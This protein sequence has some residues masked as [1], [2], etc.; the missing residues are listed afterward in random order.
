MG[1]KTLSNIQGD[2]QSEYSQK[3][4]FSTDG[5]N[6]F[7]NPFVRDFAYLQDTLGGQSSFP[8]R[9]MLFPA[10]PLALNNVRMISKT[11]GPPNIYNSN[12]SPRSSPS[13][14][15]PVPGSSHVCRVCSKTFRASSLLDIHM[16]VHVGAKP[17]VCPMC[18][19]RAT[20][21]GN[22]KLHMKKHH[23]AD[24]PPHIDLVPDSGIWGHPQEIALSAGSE[25]G[26]LVDASG[27]KKQ[28]A[29]AVSSLLNEE[30]VEL[31][32]K[33]QN[34]V[35]QGMTGRI[36]E[37]LEDFIRIAKSKADGSIEQ[38][39][40]APDSSSPKSNESIPPGRPKKKRPLNSLRFKPYSAENSHPMLSLTETPW[41]ELGHDV[42]NDT[43]CLMC[44]CSF[45]LNKSQFFSSDNPM[46]P[47]CESCTQL[48][49]YTNMISRQLLLNKKP[50]KDAGQNRISFVEEEAPIT[51]NGVVSEKS[52]KPD[53]QKTFK[54]KF[55]GAVFISKTEFKIHKQTLH[56]PKSEPSCDSVKDEFLK[57]LGLVSKPI[58]DSNLE[59]KSSARHVHGLN[60]ILSSA[61]WQNSKI[62]IAS[63]VITKPK[64][65][66]K[67]TN[68]KKGVSL[69]RA[70]SESKLQISS[71]NRASPGVLNMLRR[72]VLN[73][74][75][76]KLVSSNSNLTNLKASNEVDENMEPDEVFKQDSTP[77]LNQISTSP[78]RNPAMQS[79][80]EIGKTLPRDLSE[81]EPELID[82]FSDAT[83]S[84]IFDTNKSKCTGS[85]SSIFVDIHEQDNGGYKCQFCPKWFKYKSVLEIHMRSH[86]GERP[87][88]C[89]YCEY[90]GT[91]HN[92]LKLHIQRHHPQE[93][94]LHHHADMSSDARG[95]SVSSFSPQSP[96]IAPNRM[97]CFSPVECPICGRVSPSPGYLKIHMRSH[98]K[99]LDHV[100]P[101]CGRGFKEYWYL[102]THLK[103]HERELSTMKYNLQQ[104][105]ALNAFM[106]SSL[107]QSKPVSPFQAFSKSAVAQAI[108]NIQMQNKFLN[109]TTQTSQDIELLTCHKQM[110]ENEISGKIFGCEFE[111][112]RR[113]ILAAG[114]ANNSNHIV[115]NSPVQSEW[116]SDN[117]SSK[118]R[119]SSG[120]TKTKS[121]NEDA[122]ISNNIK[123]PTHSSRR[124]AS[125]PSRITSAPYTVIKSTNYHSNLQSQN[126]SIQTVSSAE[127]RKSRP[128]K[129]YQG[130]YL[131][132]P[133]ND[134]NSEEHVDQNKDTPD[135]LQ[136]VTS[137]TSLNEESK[138]VLDDLPLD[139]SCSTGK[140]KQ[141]RELEQNNNNVQEP[142]NLSKM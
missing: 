122:N 107:Q 39:D 119:F 84:S 9:E 72:T 10:L 18:G 53:R 34:N 129:A 83:S 77:E 110:K 88:K 50:L 108:A 93:Y 132:P 111:S 7:A 89:T 23:G 76:Q 96:D 71:Q 56:R 87:Y 141:E 17:F 105:Q 38:N 99:S 102:S 120:N 95:P 25:D 78:F 15:S 54:C 139:L 49:E 131:S 69:I 6:F 13:K 103:T 94:V 51:V 40:T 75:E 22:L 36:T 109:S 3:M 121:S 116:L 140:W 79:L 136:T 31:I 44:G 26:D 11:K 91:Q 81:Q 68:V 82:H 45:Y 19:H 98:K 30:I 65:V 115:R 48:R 134:L 142:L 8:T 35:G 114:N 130:I 101:V 124:K 64:L 80:A 5:P 24:L 123:F 20:Q 70:S 4:N 2:C 21:K 1:V 104:P 59:D 62:Q 16:R 27:K 43:K 113:Q 73:S 60:P 14:F 42:S 117:S 138:A 46:L 137:A 128:R 106:K 67:I 63:S 12:L 85:L 133:L 66:K 52:N 58:S 118:F 61:M 47:I 37:S 125:C 127:R 33:C 74:V 55:C 126:S 32:K 90:A 100:C 28:V 57:S 86:T 112:S 92:C 97:S 135:F 29:Q 41:S